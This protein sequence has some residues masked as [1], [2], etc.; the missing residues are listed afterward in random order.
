MF[1]AAICQFY[2]AFNQKGSAH[3]TGVFGSCE[4]KPAQLGPCAL[5]I[6]QWV[7]QQGSPEDWPPLKTESSARH[8]SDP[9]GQTRTSP[10]SMAPFLGVQ[11]SKLA[12]QFERIV[13]KD[14][15]PR[16]KLAGFVQNRSQGTHQ[17]DISDARH[18]GNL[19]A[20]PALV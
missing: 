3:R 18:P 10:A 6:L 7:R 14:A 5:A 4:A 17:A 16:R 12:I 20:L 19:L 1:I 15:P 9:L 8:A 2:E 11:P 13:E